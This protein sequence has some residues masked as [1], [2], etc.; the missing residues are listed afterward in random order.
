MSTKVKYKDYFVWKTRSSNLENFVTLVDDSP[1]DLDDF[2]RA[3]HIKFFESYLPNDWIY[4]MIGDAFHCLD[5]DSLDNCTIEGDI[6]DVDLIEWLKNSYAKLYCN[7]VMNDMIDPKDII[8]IISSGQYL[9]K[10]TIYEL[11]N[12]F[13]RLNEQEEE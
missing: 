1:Q 2:V 10:R 12:D 7:E 5:I 13:L 9:A 3:V 6:F 4:E 11:V 8:G